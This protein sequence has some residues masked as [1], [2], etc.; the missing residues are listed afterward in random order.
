MEICE[1][2]G[3]ESQNIILRDAFRTCEVY[4]GAP[5][6][7][8]TAWCSVSPTFRVCNRLGPRWFWFVNRR[9]FG[10]VGRLFCTKQRGT[11]IPV[12]SSCL[13]VCKSS[14]KFSDIGLAPSTRLFWKVWEYMTHIKKMFQKLCIYSL[15][16]KND[17]VNKYVLVP[18]CERINQRI[19]IFQ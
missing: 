4:W 8:P 2:W 6:L 14:R 19:G 3:R 10:T 11:S 15:N 18:F 1:F 12:S 5:E 13:R 7:W 17:D 16:L 9:L